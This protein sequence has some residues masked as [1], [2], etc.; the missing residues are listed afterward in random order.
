MQ[1][2]EILDRAQAP[3]GQESIL[4]RR[5][6]EYLIRVGGWDLMSSRDDDSARA[7]ATVGC[8]ALP[9]RAGLRV[10]IG[11]LG[12]GYSLAAA[13]A[14]VPEDAEVELAELIPAVVEWNRGPLQDLAGAPLRDPRTRVHVGDVASLIAKAP[15]ATWDAILLDVD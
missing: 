5:G 15:P 11:G 4:S 14:A 2:W 8:G 6:H 3:D 12:M 1:P 10:L 13:L 9:R 7:L